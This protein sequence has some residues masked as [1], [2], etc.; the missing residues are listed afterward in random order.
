MKKNRHIIVSVLAVILFVGV[1]DS[2]VALIDKFIMPVL[3]I[4][5]N[6]WLGV[7]FLV[8]NIVLAISLWKGWLDN[9]KVVTEKEWS[10][11]FFGEFVYWYFHFSQ[12]Y[13]YDT[14]WNSF[15]AYLDPAA[16]LVVITA[17]CSLFY[18]KRQG[19]AVND[20]ENMKV[21]FHRDD[22]ILSLDEDIFRLEGFVNRIINYVENTNVSRNAYSIGLVGQWG[23]GKTSLMNLIKSKL[24]SNK[25]LII[26]FNP[27][28]SKNAEHIQSDFLVKLRKAMKPYVTGLGVSFDR[29][30][31][32]IN[33]VDTPDFMAWLIKIFAAH[34]SNE[35]KKY[36]DRIE[37]AIDWIE[38]KIV[39]FVDDLDRSI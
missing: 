3:S 17:V 36:R 38:K 10:W 8:V 23:E 24:P 1:K 14:Y 35:S 28:L 37:D 15:I 11:L 4:E 33:A 26:D 7:F 31:E 5:A 9:R 20:K 21:V 22:A 29:Y 25:F 34:K 6:T 19:V 12:Y 39:V 16:L 30:A 13:S 2:V 18:R 27:R 32:S